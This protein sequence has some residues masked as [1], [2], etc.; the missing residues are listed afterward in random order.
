MD[1]NP[2]SPLTPAAVLLPVYR[3]HL[4]RLLLGFGALLGVDFFQLIIPRLIKRGVDGLAAGTVTQ[5]GLLRIGTMILAAALLMTILRFFWRFLIIGFSRILERDIRDRLF[6]HLLTLDRAFFDHHTTGDIMAHAANDLGAVQMACG[7]GMVAAV[8]AMVIA[9]AGLGFMLYISPSLT[10]L[11]VLPMPLLALSTRRLAGRLH[12]RFNRVQEQFS[13]LTEFARASITGIRLL[14][15]YTMEKVQQRRFDRLGREYIRGNLRV[16]AIQGMLFPVAALV[17]NLGMLLVLYY[18]GR[19]AIEARITLGDFAAFMTYL[20]MLVWPMMAVGWV[21]NLAQR[22]MTS[23]GRIVALLQASPSLRQPR[24]RAGESIG[25][26]RE[27]TFSCRGLSFAYDGD[28]GEV[29]R[30]IDLEI[31]PGVVGVVG[32]PGSGKSTLCHLLARLYPIPD[33]MLFIN[34]IDVNTIAPE[35]VREKI[36]YVE[37]ESFLFSDTIAANIRL[38][39]PGAG[40]REMEK[41]ARIAAIHDEIMGFTDG[42]EAII[43]ERGVN[44]SGGQRQRLALARAL[45]ADRPVLLIDDALSAVDMATEKQIITALAGHLRDKTVLL[46]SHR[47]SMLHDAHCIVVLDDGKIVGQGSHQQLFRENSYYRNIVENQGQTGDAD[48]ETVGN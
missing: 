18:G 26:S 10:M 45:L 5:T 36:A 22:G 34:G 28:Q 9:V 6:S 4:P 42:Y 2:G 16:A 24:S 13:L 25:V 7:M 12:R 32:P 11:A 8:D 15:V 29:L 27:I 44:L 20:T 30:D 37:Q 38:G 23:L 48:M 40:F 35:R 14:K 46:V 43:G 33:A 17:G 19:L 39:N 1:S 41:A 47:L 21:T 3:R 31:G